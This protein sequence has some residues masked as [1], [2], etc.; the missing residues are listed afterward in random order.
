MNKSVSME[1]MIPIIEEVLD[2]EGSVTFTPKG[3]SML[4]LLLGDRDTVTLSKP[5]FPL[6]KYDIPLYKRNN[7]A[8]VLHRIIKVDND[9]YV[10]RGD[11]QT[12]DEK[13]IKQSQIIA[14]VTGF[15]RKNKEYNMKEFSYKLYCKVWVNSLLLKKIIVK[16]IIWKDKLKSHK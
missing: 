12:V 13:G 5:I 15:N 8:Y 2:N 10:M 7:G 16:L 11:N 4:P 3:S 6:K 14:V 9:S 1:D